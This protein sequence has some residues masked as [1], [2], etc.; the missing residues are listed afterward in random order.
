MQHRMI[1]IVRNTTKNSTSLHTIIINKE[2]YENKIII[3]IVVSLI[4]LF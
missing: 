4:K 3:Y 2:K 1:T